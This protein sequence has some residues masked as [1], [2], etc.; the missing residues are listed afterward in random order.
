M[1]LENKQKTKRENTEEGFYEYLRNKRMQTVVLIVFVV[2]TFSILIFG[3]TKINNMFEVPIAAIWTERSGKDLDEIIGEDDIYEKDPEDL[4]KEDT[5]EDGLND[6][7]EVY[8]Y[9]TSPYLSDTDS[10]GVSDF[11]E[12]SNYEDPNCPIGQSC[13]S[14]FVES[15]QGELVEIPGVGAGV[16]TSS[17]GGTDQIEAYL[18]NVSAQEIRQAIMQSGAM[19]LDQLQAISDEDLVQLY[20]QALAENPE[21]I[22][23]I[24]NQFGDQIVTEDGGETGDLGPLGVPTEVGEFDVDKAYTS[25]ETLTP[26][27]VRALLLEQGFT[28]EELSGLSDEQIMAVYEAALAYS[29]AN[30]Q[31]SN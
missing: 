13:F 18:Q 10:D 16:A 30:Y 17:S 25:L 22:E 27:Q 2:L 21:A 5:D 7:E 1:V 29:R 11:E 31:E 26:D 12:I 9:L 14:S 3:F 8:I 15:G 6:F 28:V 20:K 24:K 23:Q 19:T 4:K